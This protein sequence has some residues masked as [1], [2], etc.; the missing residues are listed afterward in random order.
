MSLQHVQAASHRVGRGARPAAVVAKVGWVNGL[1]TIRSLGRAGIPVYALDYGSNELGFYSR[2][3]EPVVCPDP[4]ER[5]L[6]FIQFLA[7]L[8]E[9]L[10]RPAPIFPSND[11][12]LNAIAKHVHHLGDRFLYP[13][14][15]WDALS[16]IQD[17]RFQVERARALGIPVPHTSTD[18]TEEFDF[19]VLGKPADPAGFWRSFREKSFRCENRPELAEAF[20]RALPYGPHVQELIPGGDDQLYTFGSYVAQDGTLL[21]SFSGRKLRQTPP[22][23]GTCRVAEAIWVDEVVEQG[24]AFVRGLGFHGISQVEFKRDPRD[25]RYK[26]MEINP[27]L[28]QWHG[29]ATACGVDLPVIAYLDAIG[30]RPNPVRM[31]REGRRWAIG[32]IP[33]TRPAVQLRPFVEALYAPDDRRPA[34]V[35]ARRLLRAGAE[36]VVFRLPRR[37][38]RLILRR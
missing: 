16:R 7:D 19:P 26:L 29:L 18:P 13:F 32:F 15:S 34:F 36:R 23:T 6:E 24:L 11:E 20:E 27:R 28:W 17:K 38:V 8:G 14:P 12:L 21:G 3:A 35:Y 10:A 22:G 25:G 1:A 30:Q 9:R 2:Y 31:T 4:M 33:G 37:L 5:E